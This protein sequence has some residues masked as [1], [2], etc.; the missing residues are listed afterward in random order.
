MFCEKIMTL[1]IY[2]NMEGS[3]NILSIYNII[4]DLYYL[5]IYYEQNKDASIQSCRFTK[6]EI[7]YMK[8]CLENI[9]GVKII[10]FILIK[11]KSIFKL[12]E[13]I[14]IRDILNSIDFSDYNSKEL[15]NLNE[16]KFLKINSYIDEK[17]NGGIKNIL[18][19]DDL[20]YNKIIINTSYYNLEWLYEFPIENTNKVF[21][22][23]KE[24][25]IDMM[26]QQNNF[27]YFENDS[28]QLIEL[29]LKQNNQDKMKVNFGI[30]LPK[31]PEEENGL[32][33]S[34]YNI[35]IIDISDIT[36]WVN[37]LKLTTIDLYLPKF[38]HHRKSGLDKIFN[39]IGFEFED[40][41]KIIHE[42]ILIVNETGY[43]KKVESEILN[44][45]IKMNANH[46]IIY[47][48]RCDYQTDYLFLLIGDY[49]G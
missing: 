43:Y 48:I 17:T 5:F 22:Y 32:E 34:V 36:E 23:K 29:K 44:K 38:R 8:N 40:K 49:Q 14:N 42:T 4:I 25:L 15:D 16:L 39:K 47:Y 11:R 7:T 13:T 30:I 41:I 24:E 6:K 10:N 12:C 1:M 9:I 46:S 37:G 2:S 31:F 18:H 3:S 27:M 35:P 26:Y 20:I 28:V 19:I 45:P 33:Y 21:F